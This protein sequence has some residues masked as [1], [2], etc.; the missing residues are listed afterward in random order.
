MVG[1][2]KS[3]LLRAHLL[4]PCHN[5]RNVFGEVLVQLIEANS[6][7]LLG[8]SC[9]RRLCLML[10]F[11]CVETFMENETNELIH[12]CR[13]GS[14]R[15]N[16]F[17]KDTDSGAVIQPGKLVRWYRDENGNSRYSEYLWDSDLLHAAF[18]TF[19]AHWF[20]SNWKSKRLEAKPDYQEANGSSEQYQAA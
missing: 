17:K 1:T 5:G 19:L 10:P 6:H 2:E 12:T 8:A 9:T 7:R 18:C 14:V 16:L 3:V 20:I 13:S 11:L 15:L 4:A